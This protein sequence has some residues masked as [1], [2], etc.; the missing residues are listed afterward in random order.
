MYIGGCDKVKS[1]I[2]RYVTDEDVKE[3][4]KDG[5]FEQYWQ[6]VGDLTEGAAGWCR[7]KV[8][9]RFALA[10]GTKYT[11][12]GGVERGFSRMNLIHQNTQRNMMAQSMLNAHMHIR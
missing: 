2:D 3:L 12:T 4:D 11:A 10:M 9:P 6:E 5:G 1:E 8:L 7:Y